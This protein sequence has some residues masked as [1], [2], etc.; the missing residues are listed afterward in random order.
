MLKLTSIALA[1]AFAVTAGAAE[2]RVSGP[3]PTDIAVPVI[4]GQTALQ[5]VD[6]RPG[7]P[8]VA[9]RAVRLAVG[10]QIPPRRAVFIARHTRYGL[11]APRPGLR[12]A[13]YNDRV[14]LVDAD[15]L[16]VVAFIGILA[17]AAN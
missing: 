2:A 12:Y 13:I 8:F 6:H 17:A 14:Y 15:T 4:A 16:A 10:A 9:R 11:P 5:Q 7:A 3:I 1:G